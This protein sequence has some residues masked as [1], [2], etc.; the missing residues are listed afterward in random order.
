MISYSVLCSAGSEKVFVV[1]GC[2]R[3]NYSSVL[4]KYSGY[5]Y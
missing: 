1:E 4:V 2:A 3:V 5:V